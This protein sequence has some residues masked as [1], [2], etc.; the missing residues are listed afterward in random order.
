VAKYTGL[1]GL[2][3]TEL[4]LCQVV[5]GQKFEGMVPVTMPPEGCHRVANLFVNEQ[6]KLVV[7]YSDAPEEA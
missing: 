5:D 7:Q 1:D 2:E 3:E 6:G 4:V